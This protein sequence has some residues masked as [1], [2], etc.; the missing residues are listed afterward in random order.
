MIDIPNE[1]DYYGEHSFKMQ[2]KDTIGEHFDWLW[3]QKL[4]EDRNAKKE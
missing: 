3:R 2:Y 4:R 1:M